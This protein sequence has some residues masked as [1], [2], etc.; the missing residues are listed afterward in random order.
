MTG[1]L[2]IAPLDRLLK[3]GAKV[4]AVVV[5][6]DRG[7]PEPLP[8]CLEPASAGPSDL[9]VAGPDLD[10][11]IVQLAWQRGIP[12][13][14]VGSLTE[15]STLELMAVLQ[16]ELIVVACFPYIFPAALLQLPRHGCW[17]LHPSLLPAY[18]GP[19]PLFWLARHNERHTGVTLHRLDEG[20]D[21]GDIVAQAGFD[22]LEGMSEAGLEQLCAELGADL[23][24]TALE[25]LEHGSIRHVP[26]SEVGASY[27]PWPSA[28]D[29]VIPTHWPA[30]H[31]FSFLRG[32]ENWPLVIKIDERPVRI[33]VAISYAVDQQLEQPYL[34]LGDELWVQFEPG[35]LRAKI[36]EE[37][38]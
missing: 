33:R 15:A 5:P 6:G 30:Q 22:R 16:P 19:A 2:S 34:L 20:L 28:S 23:L 32:A 7:C 8:R 37:S 4:G 1:Q 26:Q 35:V 21:T 3:A 14:E 9:P 12:V 24:L 13:W 10:H 17:N 36:W 27:F 18:R 31:A 25:Q 38:T 29:F 11:S